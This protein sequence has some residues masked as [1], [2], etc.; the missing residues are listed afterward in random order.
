LRKAPVDPQNIPLPLGRLLRSYA[1][2]YFGPNEIRLSP[3]SRYFFSDFRA[4][5]VLFLY[6]AR[7]ALSDLKRVGR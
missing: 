6:K 5:T 3:Q 4:G 2:D 1:A 7:A